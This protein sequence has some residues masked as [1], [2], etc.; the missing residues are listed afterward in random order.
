[1]R[2]YEKL[3][4]DP[5]RFV[6]WMKKQCQANSGHA[7]KA[8]DVVSGFNLN[9]KEVLGGKA[10]QQHE[11]PK[12]SINA[13]KYSITT[14]KQLLQ[15]TANVNRA[16]SNDKIIRSDGLNRS[17]LD[18]KSASST[19]S[20]IYSAGVFAKEVDPKVHEANS[21]D[22]SDNKEDGGK[23]ALNQHFFKLREQFSTMHGSASRKILE[24]QFELGKMQHMSHEFDVLAEFLTSEEKLSVF[25]QNLDRLQQTVRLTEEK[26]HEINTNNVKMGRMI[27]LIGDTARKQHENNDKAIG[28]IGDR[29]ARWETKLDR[30][31]RKIVNQRIDVEDLKTNRDDYEP[32][33]HDIEHML[34]ERLTEVSTNLENMKNVV[35]CIISLIVLKMFVFDLFKDEITTQQP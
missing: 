2:Q 23:D 19:P 28:A 17:K 35:F 15:S 4:K 21:S 16:H 31:A 20:A 7:K 10:E 14:A 34:N 12:M 8:F 18:N 25:E 24:L 33:K 1:M 32:L 26:I 9:G 3:D 29:L 13:Q 5:L 30:V 6:H 11:T 27:R 22:V